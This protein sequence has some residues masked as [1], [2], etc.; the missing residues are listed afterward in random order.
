[1]GKVVQDKLVKDKELSSYKPDYWG[2]YFGAHWAPPCRKF[3]DDLKTFYEAVN[4]G[5]E[6]KF[7]EVIF[8]SFD[9]NEAHFDRHYSQH[10]WLAL[11]YAD[12]ARVA[13]LKVKFDLQ[14]LPT[15]AIVDPTGRIVKSNS[16]LDIPTA[17]EKAKE[18]FATWEG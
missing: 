10:P 14:E 17:G 11:P 13:A 12:E 1:M 8:V 7:F 2:I 16:R 9:G 15:L 3:N 5:Q 18:C 6:K 4:K